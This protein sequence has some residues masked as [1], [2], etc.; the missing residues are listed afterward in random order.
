MQ[1]AF[2][3]TLPLV[4]LALGLVWIGISRVD[5]GSVTAGRVPA[6]QAGF[7]APDFTLETLGG[8]PTSLSNLR[9]QPVVINFWASWCPPC[10]SEMPAIQIIQDEYQGSISILAVN[11]TNQDTL[12]NIQ[13]FLG[14]FGLSFPVLLDQAGSVNRLYKVTSL[15][16]TFFIDAQGIIREVVI[17]GPLTEAGLRARIESLSQ[18]GP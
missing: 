12:E 10:R 2:R 8:Q 13:A 7:L 15:P 17:G 6:P 1:Y 4:L 16:T 11:S 3:R 5:P 18:V 9:G 14:E